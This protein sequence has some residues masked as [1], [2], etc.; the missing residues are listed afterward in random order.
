M[1]A[2]LSPKSIIEEGNPMV[3]ECNADVVGLSSNI[4]F[5][6]QLFLSRR[7]PGDKRD[8]LIGHYNPVHSEDSGGSSKN[9]SLK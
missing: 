3:F 1:P 8:K 7:L 5:I 2:K 4:T 9:V 6:D